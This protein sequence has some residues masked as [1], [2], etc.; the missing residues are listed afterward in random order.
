V[1]PISLGIVLQS[2]VFRAIFV[3]FCEAG[4]ACAGPAEPI[5]QSLG[6]VE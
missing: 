2:T 1:Q 4:L 6:R 3:P 5:R